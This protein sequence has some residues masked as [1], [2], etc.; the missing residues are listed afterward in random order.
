MNGEPNL[1]KIPSYLKEKLKDGMKKESKSMSS[2][3]EN[4]FFCIT[5]VLDSLPE[6]SSPNAKD[7][8][9]SRMFIDLEP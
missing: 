2:K 8:M 6:D 3:L 4:M 7:P 1:K 9:L 5:L